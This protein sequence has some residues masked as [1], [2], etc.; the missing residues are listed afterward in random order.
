[1]ELLKWP[2]LFCG[3]RAYSS[4]SGGW[5]WGGWEGLGVPEQ[6]DDCNYPRTREAQDKAAEV[7]TEHRGCHSTGPACSQ[8][9]LQMG[10]VRN[11]RD[12]ASRDFGENVLLGAEVANS[13]CGP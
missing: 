13:K 6:M 3:V 7:E 1:M 8:L 10:G 4:G 11:V 12:A 2:E 5:E 9:F